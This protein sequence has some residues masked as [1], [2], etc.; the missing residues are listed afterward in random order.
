MSGASDSGLVKS[1][2]E[3]TTVQIGVI[4]G[5]LGF[6]IGAVWFAATLN[7]KV[8]SLISITTAQGKLT[9][10]VKTE[11]DALEKRVWKL[12]QSNRP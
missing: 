7:A 10:T 4:G 1:I 2:G 8:D 11:Q 3:N 5:V 6:V 9:E 12:E